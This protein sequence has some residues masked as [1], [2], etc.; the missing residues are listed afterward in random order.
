MESMVSTQ[1]TCYVCIGPYMRRL[2]PLPALV[3]FLGLVR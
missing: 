1:F 3:F 2:T